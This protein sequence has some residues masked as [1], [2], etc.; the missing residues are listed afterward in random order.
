M[1]LIVAFLELAG[2][3]VLLTMAIT[4]ASA[5]EVLKGQAG[6]ALT[7]EETG[8]GT[9][10]S[11]TPSTGTSSTS[12]NGS[13]A[14]LSDFGEITVADLQQVGASHGWSTAEL[15]AWLQVI[16]LESNGTLTDTNASSGAYGIAQFINGAGEYAQY[17]GNSTTVL[18]QLT[19]MANYIAQRYGNPT[20]ALAFHLANN[21]Y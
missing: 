14:G 17:G 1:A 5:A 12:V 8:T 3:V 18:G 20:K 16:K 6:Q 19:A 21:W 11:P 2:G 4:G 7:S 10:A 15:E 13:T 9:T